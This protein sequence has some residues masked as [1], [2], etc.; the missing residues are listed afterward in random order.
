MLMN[1]KEVNHL[2]INGEMFDKSFYLIKARAIKDADIGVISKSGEIKPE[3][4]GGVGSAYM[5]KGRVITLI[6]RYRNAVCMTA[7]DTG[8]SGWISMNDIEFIDAT[9]G[10]NKPSYL[11]FIYY[12]IALL[13]W[14][15]ALAC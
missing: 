6:A 3:R 15:V 2:V 10:V 4:V 1:G 7:E 8:A 13:V 12:C 14:G 9:G 11:L 5:P